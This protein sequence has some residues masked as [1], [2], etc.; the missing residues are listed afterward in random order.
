[1]SPIDHPDPGSVSLTEPDITNRALYGL[2]TAL[3]H[4]LASATDTAVQ[5]RSSIIGGRCNLAIGTLLPLTPVLA[6][7]TQL[8]QTVLDLHRLP[9]SGDDTHA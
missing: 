3:A 2:L 5:A 6:L 1:M 7:C 9:Q 4:H 8:L